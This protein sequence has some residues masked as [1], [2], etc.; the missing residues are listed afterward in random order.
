MGSKEMFKIDDY[1]ISENTAP[2]IIAE[3]SA[4]HNGKIEMLLK[5]LIWQSV[6]A[7]MP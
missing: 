6:R 5:L 4:N 2:Y 7:Q 3:I 1:E